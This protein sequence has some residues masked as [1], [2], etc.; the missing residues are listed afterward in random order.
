ML[1]INSKKSGIYKIVNILNNNCYIGSTVNFKSRTHR[2]KRDLERKKHHSTALQNAIN[3]YGEDNF[4]F[5]IICYTPPERFYLE[6]MEQKFFTILNPDYNIRYKPTNC[7]GLYFGQKSSKQLTNSQVLDIKELLIKNQFTIKE[8]AKMYK[9]KPYTINSI[10]NGQCWSKVVGKMP[11]KDGS[12]H[13]SRILK[14]KIPKNCTKLNWVDIKEIRSNFKNREDIETLAIKYNLTTISI[15]RII[16]NKT[17]IDNNYI[18]P[19]K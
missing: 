11:K 1:V 7:Y 9:V 17:W 4:K 12:K 6:K 10:S 15:Y 8:I 14:G 19:I 3:K 13:I 18:N 16:K 2:H 5:E